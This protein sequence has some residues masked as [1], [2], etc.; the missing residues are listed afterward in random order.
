MNGIN[1]VILVATLGQD[2][3]TKT[4]P[5]GGMLAKVSVATTETWNDRNTGQKQERTD[6]HDVKFNSRLAEIAAQY[7]KKGSKVYLEGQLRKE[8][9]DDKNTGKKVYRSYVAVKSMQMLD[10][11]ESAPQQQGGQQQAPAQQAPQQAPAQQ[12]DPAGFGDFDDDIP[13]SNYELKIIV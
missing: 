9:W 12:Q 6:W 8:S 5:D 4:F 10:S 2:V 1:K 3:E 7:L 11:R 13:F